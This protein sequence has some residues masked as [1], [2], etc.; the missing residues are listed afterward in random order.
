MALEK[1]MKKSKRPWMQT[2]SRVHQSLIL[3]VLNWI[4][5]EQLITTTRDGLFIQKHLGSPENQTEE[6]LELS[7]HLILLS[8]FSLESFVFL[9]YRR[10]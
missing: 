2:L 1:G 4:V 8:A 7:L 10:V 9:M 5:V 6:S 3:R